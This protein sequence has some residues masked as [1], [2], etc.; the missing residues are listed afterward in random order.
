MFSRVCG[1]GRVRLFFPPLLLNI[2]SELFGFF[3]EMASF[4]PERL[5]GIRDV[6]IVPFKLTEDG[7]TLEGLHPIGQRA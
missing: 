1:L 3:V 4:E 2:D 7:F 5:G 6:V